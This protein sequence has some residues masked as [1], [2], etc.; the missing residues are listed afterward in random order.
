MLKNWRNRY[1]NSWPGEAFHNCSM[2]PLLPCNFL[3]MCL[4][5]H[6]ILLSN[7]NLRNSPKLMM[8]KIKN[9]KEEGHKIHLFVDKY[10]IFLHLYLQQS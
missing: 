10:Y 4:L 3:I 8:K 2:S 1:H 7:K 5:L 9:N 6:T